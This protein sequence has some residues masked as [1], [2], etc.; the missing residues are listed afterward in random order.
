MKIYFKEFH[1]GFK[2]FKAIGHVV[3]GL[4]LV[5]DK[6]KAAAVPLKPIPQRK[7][8]IQSFL[9]FSGLYRKNIEDFASI[10]RD[11][12]KFW[13]KDTVFEMTV[14]VVKAFQSMRQALTTSSLL[15]M[16]D[17]KVTFKLCIDSSGD[18]LGA[19]LHQVH[20]IN[21]RRVEG[22]ICYISRQI[23]PTEFRYGAIKMEC[24]CLF[25]AL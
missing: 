7:K 18:V 1:S 23:K 20:I 13:D 17:F 12:Y 5:F 3:S 14:E 8:E 2:E 19:A 21:E 24:L 6:S 25:W 22:P 15:L 16:P 9:G 4:S 11:I 10:A